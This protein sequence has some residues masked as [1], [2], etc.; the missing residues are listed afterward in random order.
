MS[1]E[2]RTRVR[3]VAAK[4]TF[5]FDEAVPRVGPRF[6]ILDYFAGGGGAS[7]GIERAL[8]RSPDIAIN[9]CAH[10]IAMHTLNHPDTD[11]VQSN[12][13]EV[14]ARRHLPPGR[15]GLTWFSP[16][17]THFSRA[18]GGKPVSKK[19]RGLAWIVLRVMGQRRP[20][21]SVIENVAEF[22]TWGPV[23]DG[24]PVKAKA[25]QHF[26]KWIRQIEALGAVVEH[27]V[28]DAA[29]Y[30]APTHRKRL[31][32]IARLDG[33]S[34]VWP[35]PTHGPGRANPYRTAAECID[36]S[37]PCPSIFG[38][39]KPLAEA[40]MRRIAEGMKRFVFQNPKPFIVQVNHGGDTNRSRA[41]DEPMPTITA[42]HG[43]AV[44]APTLVQTGYGER[45]GQKPRALDIEAPL[46][47]VVAGGA[48]H[49]VVTA[50]LA[51]HYGGVVGHMPDRPI[52]TV[53]AVDHH[54]VVMAH[55]TKFYGT[56]T[57]QAV[58]APAPTIT[59]Q[60]Q[61][62]GLVAAF[63]I[64]YYGQ[65]TGQPLS[66]PLH[67]VVSKARFGLVTIDLDGETYALVDIG[68]R[69]LTPRELARCQ[70]FD[71]GYQLTGTQA[72]QTARIGNSVS[73]PMAEAIVR[74]NVTIDEKRPMPVAAE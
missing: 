28:L 47:T 72:E 13:W 24:Q 66:E 40:T 68:L 64:K 73:P 39:K 27:R 2:T 63:C 53:T 23:R 22:R 5:L 3:K 60:G 55:L 45:E 62:V 26:R 30:G 7:H 16:D 18:K 17:C 33:K 37:I 31:F 36:W 49:A 67:T 25:G 51:K 4:Q 6:I 70:G 21:V 56:S 65:G 59:G 74:A 15:V 14:N 9:H 43:F 19:I 29:D 34:I 32:V 50:W 1:A 41:A 12:V 20:D 54:S 61:H 38:R 42:K 46:G 71:E 10:A 48:K 58:D 52:G 8:G 57:G 11:H 35:E 44:I 69:M